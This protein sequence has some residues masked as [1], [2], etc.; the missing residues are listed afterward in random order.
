MAVKTEVIEVSSGPDMDIIDITDKVAEAVRKSGFASGIVTVFVSGSTAAVTTTE[1]EPNLSSDLK[2]AVERLIPS[3]IEYK[4]KE[5]WGDDN[6]KSHIRASLFKP[7]LTIPFRDG[8]LM[9]GTWQQVV[10]LDFDV[11]ARTRKIVLQMI[12]E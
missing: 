12:G 4:H 8:E 6:G 5:T 2:N 1:F 3:D 11:P 7:D 9:L 10:V